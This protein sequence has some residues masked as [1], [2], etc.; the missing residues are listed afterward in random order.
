AV[1]KELAAGTLDRPVFMAYYVTSALMIGGLMHYM[2][3]GKPPEQL[4]DYTHPQSGEKDQYGKPI[5]LN[6]MFY[7]R[8]FEGLYK[9]MQQEGT[10]SG[11]EEFI[12]N[13]GSGLMEMSRTALTG[14]NSLGNDIRNPEDPAY[15][16]FEQTLFNTLT[17]LDSISIE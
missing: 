8:E 16:Q 9:H 14:V 12:A 13:K 7:T 2:F 6:T 15:K 11:L 4:I 10:A 3:T 5:R 17:G 1:K